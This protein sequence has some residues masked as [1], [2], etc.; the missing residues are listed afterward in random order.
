MIQR[1]VA[2]QE[3]RGIIPD[4]AGQ[5]VMIGGQGKSGETPQETAQ[6]TLREQTGIN[7]ADDQVVSTYK[8]V[9]QQLV[10]LKDTSYNPFYV[11]YLVFTGRD[12]DAFKSL[13]VSALHNTPATGLSDGVLQAA[14]VFRLPAALTQVGPVK[15][16]KD[17]WQ[18]YLV[19]NYYGG[20][21]P[22]PFN[23]E[24]GDLTNL[25]TQRSV[26]DSTWFTIGINNLP[27][28]DGPVPPSGS[29]VTTAVSIVNTT[30]ANLWLSATIASE[31]D[32]G[33]T[34]NRPDV[35]IGGGT[36]GTPTLAAF[37][38]LMAIEDILSTATSARYTVTVTFEAPT[39]GG[40]PGVV[41]VSFSFE[42]NQTEARS[43]E[44]TDA[45]TRNLNIQG[46]TT[47]TWA[48]SQ[49]AESPPSRVGMR[50]L[51]LYLLTPHGS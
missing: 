10:A 19:R 18:N 15:P 5:W 12:L 26:Q 47:G 9:K 7:L 23:L 33:S 42:V 3:V 44:A 8:V 21:E 50:G 36:T 37:G 1:R 35:N 46:D 32:W 27:T 40:S 14:E 22:G 11:L 17:G 41:R 28:A 51:T 2:G 6:R 34:A 20:T 29:V 49:V 39:Q 16:P 4:W 31:N 30:P 45:S 24:I 25:L 13:I 38:S 48:V 43:G